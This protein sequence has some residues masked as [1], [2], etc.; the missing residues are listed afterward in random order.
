MLSP[1]AEEE[2]RSWMREKLASEYR[3][4]DWT[5]DPWFIREEDDWLMAAGF[6]LHLRSR[7][8]PHLCTIYS[9]DVCAH[10]LMT[11]GEGALVLGLFEHWPWSLIPALRVAGDVEAVPEAGRE[12]IV[13][14]LRKTEY[15]SAAATELAI[16]ASLVR[17]GLKVEREPAV[18]DGDRIKRPD[19]GVPV[20]GEYYVIEASDVQQSA[21]EKAAHL[22][23]EE[24]SFHAKLV[25]GGRVVV[26][27]PL[28][29]FADVARQLARALETDT[30][31]RRHELR[32]LIRTQIVPAFEGVSS[33][34]VSA[35]EPRVLTAGSLAKVRV[36]PHAEEWGEF[37]CELMADV[38]VRDLARRVIAKLIDE[39]DQLVRG[40][41]AD[42]LSHGVIV[43]DVGR[44]SELV[45]LAD[46]IVA[47]LH[48][49][50]N[51][52]HFDRIERV[53]S[54][55][56]RGSWNVSDGGPSST[57]AHVI[58]L[59]R[60][61]ANEKADADLYWALSGGYLVRRDR[62][63]GHRLVSRLGVEYAWETPN[64]SSLNL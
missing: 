27:E 44:A 47:I 35:T 29:G 15:A 9:P 17:S 43:L 4:G 2:L 56:L 33:V 42:R 52:R 34:V 21:K 8:L 26:V 11:P 53:D 23:E 14:Q 28:P 49:R 55:V 58:R 1:K 32:E 39:A 40:G 31:L 63:R 5:K 38:G 57:A 46:E 37:R 54:L 18:R 7:L 64:A 24:L 22:L 50:P 41:P 20:R 48:S 51:I 3:N 12:R 6:P 61:A 25:R 36:D 60:K 30:P 16:W 59:W 10:L 45:Q 13:R 19:F 62:K